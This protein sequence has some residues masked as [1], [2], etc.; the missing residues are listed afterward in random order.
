MD[1][2]VRG[3]FLGEEV[4]LENVRKPKSDSFFIIINPPKLNTTAN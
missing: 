2:E 1:D 4:T 3:K